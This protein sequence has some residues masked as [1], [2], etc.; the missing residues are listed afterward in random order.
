MKKILLKKAA[1]A[2]IA[3]LILNTAIPNTIAYSKSNEDIITSAD[4]KFMLEQSSKVSIIDDQILINEAIYKVE[5]DI[6]NGDIKLNVNIE[7]L[8]FENAKL[9]VVEGVKNNKGLTIPIIKDDYSQF[10]N[11]TVLLNNDNKVTDYAESNITKSSNNKFEIR[12][13]Q[14]GEEYY[15]E[16]TDIEYIENEEVS[17]FLTEVEEAVEKSNPNERG[18]N[19]ACFAAISGA[20]AGIAGLILKL[21]GAP[22]VLAPPVCIVCLGGI[23]LTGGGGIAGAVWACWE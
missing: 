21:C 10:S 14:N 20:G 19:L 9:S 16:V 7:E 2:L 5:S 13:F 11:L 23:I 6:Y 17:K 15:N 22:C 18:L 12:L 3:V 1:M 4:A 8:D